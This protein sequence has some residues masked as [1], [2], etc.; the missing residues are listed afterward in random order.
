MPQT[1]FTEANAALEAMQPVEMT[2]R[3]KLKIERRGFFKGIGQALMSMPEGAGLGNVLARLGGGAL[4]GRMSGQDEVQA[5]MD[6]FDDKM[7]AYKAAVYQNRMAEAQVHGKEAADN[8]QQ[9]NQW[10]L[11]KW[12]TTYQQWSKDNQ[13][14]VTGD[15]VVSTRQGK[16]G[17]IRSRGRRSEPASRQHS[18]FSALVSTAE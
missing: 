9:M 11:T 5:R 13:V 4:A 17:K 2:E 18:L 8:V 16:D 12:N 6:K 3:D 1:D 14:D 7:A 15:A 10:A